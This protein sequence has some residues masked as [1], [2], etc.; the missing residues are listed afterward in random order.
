[1]QAYETGLKANDTRLL[2]KPDSSFFRFFNDP[3]GQAAGGRGPARRAGCAG[4]RPLTVGQA[5]PA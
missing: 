5:R 4:A 1:M 3:I 2:L